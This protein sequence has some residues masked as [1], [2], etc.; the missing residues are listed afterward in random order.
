MVEYLMHQPG[1]QEMQLQWEIWIR[2][3]TN[4]QTKVY[5]CLRVFFRF[6]LAESSRSEIDVGGEQTC[7]LYL[8]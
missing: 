6:L 3:K 1:F 5:E 8:K 7:W 4:K 2:K